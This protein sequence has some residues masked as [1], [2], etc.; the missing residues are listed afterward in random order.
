MVIIS[1]NVGQGEGV[2]TSNIG[3]YTMQVE[4]TSGLRETGE[5]AE[6][7]LGTQMREVFVDISFHN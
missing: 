5:G 2:I 4:Q 7:G 3:D 6:L 1:S